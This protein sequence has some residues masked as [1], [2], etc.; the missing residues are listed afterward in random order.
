MGHP[1]PLSDE[2][3]HVVWGRLISSDNIS[4]LLYKLLGHY[5]YITHEYSLKNYLV[6][7]GVGVFIDEITWMR[8]GDRCER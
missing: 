2:E 7:E 4:F 8:L 6:E 3:E 5:V 1:I